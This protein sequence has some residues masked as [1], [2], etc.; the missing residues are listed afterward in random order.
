M[1]AHKHWRPALALLAALST[2]AYA[3]FNDG[4]YALVNGQFEKALQTFVPLAEAQ[5]HPYAQY[6]LGMM[7]YKGQGVPQDAVEAAKWFTKAAAQGV[8]QAQYRLGTLYATGDGV[9]Q[10]YETA[11]AWYTV[12]DKLGHKQAAAGLAAASENLSPEETIEAKRLG[13]EFS[14][15]YGK[16]P[17]AVQSEQ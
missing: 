13:R 16:A 12:A 14:E 5:N 17:E 1:T 11:Y 9:T 10:D 8:S 6:M 2:P 7:Y 3:D 4:V 15:K